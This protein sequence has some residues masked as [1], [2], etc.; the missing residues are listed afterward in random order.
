M[1]RYRKRIGPH[2]KRMSESET[3][4]RPVDLGDMIIL[5]CLMEGKKL[6][7]IAF[8]F[9]V[10]LSAICQRLKHLN[11]CIPVCTQTVNHRVTLTP[12][13]ES[14]AEAADVLLCAVR[15]NMK[16]ARKG[17]SKN[18]SKG[19]DSLDN[20]HMVDNGDLASALLP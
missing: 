3:R 2:Y 19:D 17:E 16:T 14:I 18:D 13:G 15:E 8:H 11:R 6:P 4:F 5:V 7:W 12:V 9:G 10:S 1:P 20:R